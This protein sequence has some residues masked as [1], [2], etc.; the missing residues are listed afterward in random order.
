MGPAD[1]AVELISDSSVRRDRLEKFT[2]YA[3]AGVPDYWLVDPRRGRQQ[4]FFLRLGDEGVCEATPP[5]AEGRVHSAVL[6][7]LWLRPEW[8]WQDPLPS[9]RACLAKIAP[10]APAPA[11]AGRT[12]TG[13]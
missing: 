7:G 8:L 9:P 2:E 5:D 12:P 1:L 4:A 13:G 11:A 10:E 3:M 6:P